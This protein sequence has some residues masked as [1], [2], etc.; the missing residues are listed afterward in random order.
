MSMATVTPISRTAVDPA[1]RPSRRPH[2]SS[3]SEYAA[4]HRTVKARKVAEVLAQIAGANPAFLTDD[5][6]ALAERIAQV[7]PLSAESRA[8]VI[9]LMG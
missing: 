2:F 7:N 6:W 3:G 9:A 1:P 8:V 5:Q 4:Y